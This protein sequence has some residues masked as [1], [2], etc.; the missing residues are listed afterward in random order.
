MAALH[1]QRSKPVEF[2]VQLSDVYAA[3]MEARGATKH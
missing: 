1:K 3:I 2:D